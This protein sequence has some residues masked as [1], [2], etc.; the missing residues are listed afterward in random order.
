VEESRSTH[1]DGVWRRSGG[2][3]GLKLAFAAAVVTGLT[4]SAPPAEPETVDV[5]GG[6]PSERVL[7]S[8][9]D[10]GLR[11]LIRQ[12]LAR[13]PQ[14]AA[15]KAQA[16]AA[17][18]RA[19]Q[20]KAMPDPMLGATGYVSRPE[21]RVGPQTASGTLSQRFPW[22][23][24]RGLREKVALRRADALDAQVEARR[25]DLVTETRRLFYEIGFLDAWQAVVGADRRTLVHYEELARSRYSAGVGIQQAVVKVQA[26][27]TKDDTR[28][29]EITD[30]RAALVAQLD[31][32]RDVPQPAPLGP[33][34]LPA[35]GEVKL[36]RAALRARALEL[37]PELAQ[38]DSEL[39]RADAVVALARKEYAPD[40]TLGASY[41]LVGRRQ[42]AAGI[43]APPP[44]DGKDVF[45]VSASINLPIWRRKL[46][47]GVEEAAELRRAADEDKRA[48]VAGIDRSLSELTE[49]LTLTWRQLR[50]LQDV[51]GIQADQSLR[52]AEAAYGAGTIGSLDLLDAERVLLEVRTAIERTRADYAIA[53]ARLEGAVGGPIGTTEGGSR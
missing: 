7:A 40:L 47:A 26:E 45:A 8:V 5:S 1:G 13:N 33:L 21:T 35:Y 34:T 19:P 37:R 3:R 50:L 2:P 38:A 16:L 46:K 31:A 9:S 49:R 24:K 48:V 25:L 6:T 32:L 44:D 12:V 36:D 27:I 11:D 39:A 53:M 10:P 30:R 29:L 22:F 18:E 23:G 43:A 51:L 15:A 20:A 28:L 42:D 41:T 14:L 4:A 17:R 52:S